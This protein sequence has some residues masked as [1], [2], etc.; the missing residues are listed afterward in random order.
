MKKILVIGLALLLG[1]CASSASHVCKMSS[2]PYQWEIDYQVDDHANVTQ[3]AQKVTVEVAD[4][5]EKAD[6]QKTLDEVFTAYLKE[7]GEACELT[8]N[9]HDLTLERIL[10]IDFALLSEAQKETMSFEDQENYLIAQL[11]YAGYTCE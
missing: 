11:E 3:M 8:E 10:T 6:I 7:Y 5:T 1:G 2:A 9:D 4:E